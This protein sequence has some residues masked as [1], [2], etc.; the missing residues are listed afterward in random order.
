MAAGIMKGVATGLS[1]PEGL[2]EARKFLADKSSGPTKRA[3]V[4]IL[5]R[6]NLN[7]SQ[8]ARESADMKAWLESHF[9]KQPN[10]KRKAGDE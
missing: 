10:R 4:Q 2:E 9:E 3:A 5:E 7:I 8:V 6:I 1:T